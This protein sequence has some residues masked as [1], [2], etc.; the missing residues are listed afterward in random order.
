MKFVDDFE[1]FLRDEVNL[2]QTLIDRLEQSVGAIENVL[3]TH[4]VFGKIFLDV[5]PAGSWAHRTIIRPVQENDEFDA[6]MLLYVKERPNWQPKDYLEQLWS[7]FRSIPR[8]KEIV[9]RKTRCI[10]IDYVTK[11]HIDVVP[12]LY[13][14]R[15]DSH[16]ITNRYE[17]E[18]IGRFEKSDPEAFNKWIDE[19]QRLTNG[20][21]IKAV[22]LVKYLRD[23]KNTFECKS[24]ILT[25]LLGNQV[26]AV[27]AG[28]APELYADVPST[29]LTL[30]GKLANT[31]QV[32]M[33]TIMDLAQTGEN[34]TDR[35][36]ETWNYEN[37]RTWIRYYAERVKDAHKEENTHLSIWKWRRVFGDNFKPDTV[38]RKAPLHDPF[39]SSVSWAGEQFIDQ[40]PYSFPF[41]INSDYRTWISGRVT[42]FAKDGETRQN[43]FRQF[44]L[45]K[46]GNIVQKNRGLEFVVMTTV[47]APYSIYWKVRNGGIEANNVQQ[48]RGEISKDQGIK[49][50]TETTL[51]IGHHYVECYVVKGGVVVS[52]DRQ[53]VIV[54]HN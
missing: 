44:E 46:H 14:E 9:Q 49:Q 34:F 20:H 2:N 45:A 27:E 8:Y 54:R 51:Y 30:L 38:I 22:R 15:F 41:R 17:P 48:L 37:F 43:G 40:P 33:P 53:N 26:N 39:S 4:D 21:F 12:Y 13:L 50:K 10:R 35:Y 42:G 23:F 52:K 25:T 24:I 36:A 16:Y 11:F 28:L 18:R 7:A 32:T 47:P 19:R 1:A 29:L 5:I 31:L 3:S 6:D